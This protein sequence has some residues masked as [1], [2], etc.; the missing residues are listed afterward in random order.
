MFP[1]LELRLLATCQRHSH[2]GTW[3]NGGSIRVLQR[4]G[5]LGKLNCSRTLGYLS[6]FSVILLK[7]LEYPLQWGCSCQVNFT[8]RVEGRG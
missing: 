1:N 8:C 3:L 6:H 4:N 5:L 7:G 2:L